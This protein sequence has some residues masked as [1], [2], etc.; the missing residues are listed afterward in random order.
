MI[1]GFSFLIVGIITFFWVSSNYQKSRIDRPLIFSRSYFLIFMTVFYF[2]LILL[3]FVLIF[4]SSIIVGIIS[5]ATLI[6]LYLLLKIISGQQFTKSALVRSYNKFK[7]SFPEESEKNILFMVIKSR[8]PDWPD[9]QIEKL[10]KNAE[11]IYDLADSITYI[12]RN[13]SE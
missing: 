13:L 10:T 9:A 3:G 1:L 12:E 11:D 2:S 7:T 5:L 8:H 6:L 4:V